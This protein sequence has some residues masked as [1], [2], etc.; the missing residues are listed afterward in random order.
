M[1]KLKRKKNK[2]KISGAIIKIIFQ[3]K[4]MLIYHI[5]ISMEVDGLKITGEFQGQERIYMAIKK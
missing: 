3:R 4:I 1:T 2:M 5:M